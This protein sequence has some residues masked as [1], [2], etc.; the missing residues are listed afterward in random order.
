LRDCLAGLGS[1]FFQRIDDA[2]QALVVDRR[3]HLRGLVQPA[4]ARQRRAAADLPGEPAPAER[5]PHHRADALV[6]AERHQRPFVVAPDERV[7]GLVG[8]EARVAVAVGGGERLHEL[9]A[10]KAAQILEGEKDKVG[11]PDDRG[12]GQDL[13]GRRGGSA[14]M[15]AAA[16]HRGHVKKTRLRNAP[17]ATQ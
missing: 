6:D 15:P 2:I 1:D 5:A 9:P 11:A 3:R 14:E 10:R 8:D 12:D 4:R 13:Q 17:I 7:I 16:P